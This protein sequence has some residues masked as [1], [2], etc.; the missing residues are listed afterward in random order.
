M[1][2]TIINGTERVPVPHD[3]QQVLGLEDGVEY[4]IERS[5]G[6]TPRSTTPEPGQSAPAVISTRSSDE[7]IRN[8]EKVFGSL[9][10]YANGSVLTD[11]DWDEAI[12]QAIVEDF[13]NE[14]YGDESGNRR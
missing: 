3:L 14:D 10:Q 6:A 8:M 11:E 1:V 4:V 9:R 13:L 12:A 5:S 2:A 7:A